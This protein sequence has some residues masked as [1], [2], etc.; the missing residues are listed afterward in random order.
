[1]TAT[2][3][4][5]NRAQFLR[6]VGGLAL[7]AGVP[8]LLTACGDDDAS[9]GGSTTLSLIGVADEKG[10]LD[11]LTKAYTDGGAGVTFKTSYAPTDQ[12][13][14]SVRAQLGGGNAPDIHVLY[15]GAGNTMSTVDLGKA[16]LLADLSGQPW[17][18]SI[19]ANLKA[20][21]SYDGKV[22]L[23]S[24]GLT[25]IGAI[26]NKSVFSAAGVQIPKTWPEL[27]TACET[28]KK[29][30]KVPIALGAQTQWVT[31]L[32]T[33]ALVAGYVY[34]DTPDFDDQMLAGKA[35]FL[36]SGWKQSMELYM[37]LRDRGFFNDNPN[38]TTLEQQTA[39]VGTGQ[40]AM[41]VQ[42]AP[43]LPAFRDAA[44][45][46]D[47][48]DMFPFPNADSADQVYTWGAAN[49]GVGVHAKSKNKDASLKFIEYLGQQEN[50]NKWCE[51]VAAIPLKR[52]A[53]SKVDPALQSFLPL[54]D[55]GRVAPVGSRWPNAEVQPT[56][57][58]VIQELLAKKITVD[59][60]LTKM[61]EAYKKQ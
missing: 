32:I 45:N 20:S 47:D 41:A 28:F 23:F 57:F 42:V 33:Y 39:M 43:L 22:Y 7:G 17:T 31:Q 55:A 58:S 13:T 15:P 1:M 24:S 60:A 12:V 16:G 30:G 27:L 21:F 18:A 29:A 6:L 25:V 10:P 34:R 51:V 4:G 36:N 59:Q 50:M 26:Y 52:D 11:V 61:D 48:I 46:K 38:G 49:V 53:S 2:D 9:G 54:L 44:T 37:S 8:G 35:T 19:P 40:A 56:H 14:T 5:L 3:N